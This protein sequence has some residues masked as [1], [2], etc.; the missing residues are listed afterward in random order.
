MAAR[1]DA[2]R[3]PDS[4]PTHYIAL[5][6]YDDEIRLYQED[7]YGNLILVNIF[8]PPSTALSDLDDFLS[9]RFSHFYMNEEV[10]F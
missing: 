3:S 10:E 8:S 5:N 2:Y 4:E 9:T 6:Y 1:I 7:N